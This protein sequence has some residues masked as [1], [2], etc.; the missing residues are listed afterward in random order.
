[1]VRKVYNLKYATKLLDI[2]RGTLYRYNKEGKIS[3]KKIDSIYFI[4][5]SDLTALRDKEVSKGRELPEVG[6]ILSYT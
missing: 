2:D 4:T 6:S 1:M 5:H 3:L